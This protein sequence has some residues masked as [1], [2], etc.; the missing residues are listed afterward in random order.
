MNTQVLSDLLEFSIKEMPHRAV[1]SFLEPSLLAYER[2]DWDRMS[3]LARDA[4]SVARRQN[5]RLGEAA[6]L[7]H[8]GIAFAQTD[9]V[10]D[11]QDVL[12][13]AIR[14]YHRDPDWR[15]RL[16]EGLATLA[17]GLVDTRRFES[18]NYYQETLNLLSQLDERFAAEGDIDKQEKMRHVCRLLRLRIGSQIPVVIID[19]QKYVLTA[20]WDRDEV[21]LELQPDVEYRVIPIA[22]DRYNEKLKDLGLSI[23]DSVLVRRARQIDDI[24]SGGL[25]VWYTTSG[26]YAFGKFERDAQG[27]VRFIQIGAE[28]TTLNVSSV[29]A[30]PRID[31]V[32]KPT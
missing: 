21:L 19:D 13:R 31:A 26:E 4:R 8:L 25:G 20:P 12:K 30:V 16:G 23:G 14:S 27:N 28:R 2:G 24:L 22:A 9:R 3:E 10:Q 11:A 17:L 29:Q 6:A 15:H 32:L 7:I 1:R 5:D 18:L